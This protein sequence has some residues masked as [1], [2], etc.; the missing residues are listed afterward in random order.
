MDKTREEKMNEVEQILV[1]AYTEYIHSAKARRVSDAKFA[2]YLGISNQAL[3]M[4]L[5]KVRLP[6]IEV[7]I[8]LSENRFIGPRI[9]DACGYPRV[10][11][12][13]D[14][15]LWLVVR[16]WEDLTDDERND[17]IHC[18]EEHLAERGDEREGIAAPVYHRELDEA[19][20]EGKGEDSW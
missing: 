14:K 1:E 4:Y 16:Y 13:L 6:D 9:F 11:R 12:I 7:C 17:T 20:R 2:R 5:N 15:K 8:R 18:M 19:E 10:A 3:S